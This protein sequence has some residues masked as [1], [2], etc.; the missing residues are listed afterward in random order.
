MTAAPP[1]AAAAFEP[2][3]FAAL[4]LGALAA[5]QEST[6]GLPGEAARLVR[7]PAER[8]LFALR[9]QLN[10]ENRYHAASRRFLA[11]MHLQANAALGPLA[12]N[13]A[14]TGSTL[15]HPAVLDTAARMPLTRNGH[16]PPRRFLAAALVTA[17]R[18]Y[19]DF[20]WPPAG[21]GDSASP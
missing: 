11:L 7:G 16:F 10:D 4:V 1:R 6:A 9:A 14:A 20:D 18:D 5:G 8:A 3:Q 21:S 13:A 15:L 2:A 17:Q 19:P 12:R